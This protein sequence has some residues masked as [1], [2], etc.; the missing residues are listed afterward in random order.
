M[1][2]TIIIAITMASLLAI[3]CRKD[4]NATL[5]SIKP[6]VQLQLIGGGMNT[7]FYS[8]SNYTSGQLN[9]KPNTK[10]NFIITA[11]DT[12]GLKSLQFV[13]SVDF[14][15]G[16]V[17][18]SPS[19]TVTSDII[20]K[21]HRIFQPDATMPYTSFILSGDFTTFPVGS[22]ES[23]GIEFYIT[24]LDFRNNQGNIS[25]QTALSQTPPGG[26]GWVTF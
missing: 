14:D 21:T 7:T 23:F 10:Y 13:T 22:S 19:H 2:T 15:F 8:D 18:S 26:F 16:T 1:K 11:S 24:T 3:G 6:K 25:L 12:G 17:V 20:N 4:G 5:D 9:L